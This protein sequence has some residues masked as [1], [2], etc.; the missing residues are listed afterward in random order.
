MPLYPDAND[1]K[2]ADGTSSEG[3]AA[4]TE[5]DIKE[6]QNSD[7]SVTEDSSSREDTDKQLYPTNKEVQNADETSEER[8]FVSE[9]MTATEKARNEKEKYD[10]KK[11][12]KKSVQ[13]LSSSSSLEKPNLIASQTSNSASIASLNGSSRAATTSINGA[14]LS[15]RAPTP[16]PSIPGAFRVP[17][18]SSST[19][20]P[21]STTEPAST[22]N[23]SSSIESIN[24][25]SE[26]ITSEDNI[27]PRDTTSSSDQIT[28]ADVEA[29]TIASPPTLNHEVTTAYLVQDELA[30]VQPIQPFYKRREGKI[31]IALVIFLLLIMAVLLGVF[32]GGLYKNDKLDG[33]SPTMAPTLSPTFDP[34]STL[35][36]VQDRGFLNCGLEDVA[37]GGDASFIQYNTDFC[38]G[39]AAV[40]FGDPEK[41]KKVIV[42]NDDRYEKLLDREVDVLYAGDAFTLEK[43]I[44]E[45]RTV[46]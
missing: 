23:R 2:N 3:V 26:D 10:D 5:V 37:E 11:N 34:R 14:S 46:F 42:N 22:T 12:S 38:R 45:V 4:S 15:S 39:L 18:I 17:G 40:V 27:S 21:S 43:G 1:L 16:S 30:E 8:L 28:T 35:E 24:E 20:G 32:L 33:L 6:R 36:V 41:Y 25:N 13:Q 19:T 44:R 31:T 9:V 7:S 29:A